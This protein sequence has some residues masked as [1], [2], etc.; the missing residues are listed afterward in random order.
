MFIVA[1]MIGLVL[2]L[3]LSVAD[4]LVESINPEELRSMGV[5][6]HP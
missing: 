1:V 6:K 5:V 4:A 2:W 3:G